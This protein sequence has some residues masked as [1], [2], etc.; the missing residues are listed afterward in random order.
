M[1][2]ASTPSWP[3]RPSTG[4]TSTGPCPRSRGPSSAAVALGLVWNWRDD[5]IPWVRRLGTIIGTQEQLAEPAQALDDSGLFGPVEEAR[6]THWQ[7]VDRK[8]IQDL[9]LSR[10]NVAV[11][12]EEAR[13]AKLAEVVAFYDDYGRGMDGMQL[14]YVTR[15]FRATVLDQPGG[16]RRRRRGRGQRRPLRRHR[17]RHAAHR[18]PLTRGAWPIRALARARTVAR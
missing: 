16:R 3:P 9:V 13:A 8:S 18:L 6:F 2:T 15:C 7:Q 5:S 10:S 14:P 12:D 1:T 11:L 4:S 17:H